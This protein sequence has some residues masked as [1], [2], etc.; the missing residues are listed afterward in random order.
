M[1]R[2]AQ[3]YRVDASKLVAWREQRLREIEATV[4]D[5]FFHGPVL[6]IHVLPLLSSE[7]VSLARAQDL[8]NGLAPHSRRLLRTIG[9]QQ[10]NAFELT[11]LNGSKERESVVKLFANGRLEILHSLLHRDQVIIGSSM[12]DD[13]IMSVLIR[14]RLMVDLGVRM[15]LLV[16]TALMKAKGYRLSAPPVIGPI[17]KGFQIDT[18]T[19]LDT[20][21]Q[22]NALSSPGDLALLMQP[23][24]DEIWQKGG[25]RGSPFFNS[26]DGWI[27]PFDTGWKEDWSRWD[28][29]L[30]QT[31][32]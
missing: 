29:D 9:H 15:P 1:D 11:T 23:V 4:T 7:P 31:R 12:E 14:S 28:F 21:I 5:D 22:E 27:G 32:V 16:A 3:E 2:L 17:G 10:G 13:I 26:R 20:Y 24:V 8:R 19:T 25:G 18:F 30:V 6:V